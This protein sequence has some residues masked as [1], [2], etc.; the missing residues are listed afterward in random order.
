MTRGFIR[1]AFVQCFMLCGGGLAYSFFHWSH[2]IIMSLMQTHFPT[3]HSSLPFWAPARGLYFFS[4]ASWCTLVWSIPSACSCL[5]WT[6]IKP[7]SCQGNMTH[8]DLHSHTLIGSILQ[9]VVKSG[10]WA[11]KLKRLHW[12][13]IWKLCLYL[14]ERCL[15]IFLARW[16]GR[17]NINTNANNQESTVSNIQQDKMFW[18]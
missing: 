18:S 2:Y 9:F 14:F 11:K 7:C 3:G 5:E 12:S 4:G 13:L 8:I 16:K 15:G 6:K 10:F 1:K 17:V